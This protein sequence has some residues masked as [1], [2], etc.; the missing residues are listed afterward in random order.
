M[1]SGTRLAGG[2]AGATTPGSLAACSPARYPD[3]QARCSAVVTEITR[4]S[5]A[6]CSCA[7]GAVSGSNGAVCIL[8]PSPGHSKPGKSFNQASR[9]RGDSTG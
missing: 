3:S 4:F 9:E 2:A 8:C 1:V 7:N 5:A 6:I